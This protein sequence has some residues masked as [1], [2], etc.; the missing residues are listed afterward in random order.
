MFT[1]D[2]NAFKEIVREALQEVLQNFEFSKP[3]SEAQRKV[4]F[5]SVREVEKMLKISHSTLY[6][7]IRAGKLKPVKLGRRTLFSII[8][9]EQIG[10]VDDANSDNKPR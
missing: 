1:F 3:A 8:D 10:R 9:V 5:L 4:E 7:L 6:A 2:V